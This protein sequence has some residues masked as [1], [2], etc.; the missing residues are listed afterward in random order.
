MQIKVKLKRKTKDGT[1]KDPL[2]GLLKANQKT[3]KLLISVSLAREL[4]PN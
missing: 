4:A 3:S 2:A 1:K